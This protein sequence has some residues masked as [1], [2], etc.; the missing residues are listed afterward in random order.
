MYTV[1][2]IVTI[3]H[4]DKQCYLKAVNHRHYNH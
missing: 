4:M 1:P 2:N 3:G